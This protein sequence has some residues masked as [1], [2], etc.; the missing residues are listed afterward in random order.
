MK[1]YR[2]QQKPGY[3]LFFLL[4]L[5][6]AVF[7][8]CDSQPRYPAPARIG[9]DFVVEVAS[10]QLETPS[11]FTY[12]YK[13]NNISFF[14]MRMK[15]GVQSYL[16]A[17]ASCYPHKRGYR[18][19]SGSVTCRFCNQYFSVNK[20]DKG[21]GGCYPIK[22]EGRTEKGKYLISLATLEAEAEKF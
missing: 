9:S 5:A 1:N 7:T 8:A 16:D 18:Y 21:L 6:V 15:N 20:L 14:V 17:C 12:K 3:Q 22:I 13:G 4:L 11:F 2:L 10:L 19:E